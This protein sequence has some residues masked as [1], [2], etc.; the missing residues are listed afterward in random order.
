MSQLNTY[1]SLLFILVPP[2]RWLYY[3]FFHEVSRFSEYLI[4]TFSFSSLEVEGIIEAMIRP[5]GKSIRINTRKITL[6]NFKLHA[7][8]QGWILT[9]T[10]I[11][12]VF[13]IDRADTSIA[14]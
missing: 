7:K 11:P 5:I 13:L 9:D 6:E 2:R 10:D 1:I 12:E 8:E 3:L 4:K 14:L